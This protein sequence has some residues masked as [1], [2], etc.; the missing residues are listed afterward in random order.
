MA[1]FVERTGTGGFPHLVDGDGT[2]WARFGADIRSSFLFIDDGVPVL[3][4]GYGQMDEARLREFVQDL[5][6]D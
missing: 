1:E 5:L 2:L 4:T 6:A 3:R